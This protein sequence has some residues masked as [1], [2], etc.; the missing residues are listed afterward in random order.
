MKLYI[1]NMVC[2]RC[3]A[4]VESELNKI[5]IQY[6]NVEIGKVDL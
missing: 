1:K 2:N 5:G 4:T 3:Q 6:D